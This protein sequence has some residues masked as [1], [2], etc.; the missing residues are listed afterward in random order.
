[1]FKC[2]RHT[3]AVICYAIVATGF[4]L[5]GL[6]YFLSEHLMTYHVEIL[7]DDWDT[8]STNSRYLVLSFQKGGGIG[9][10]STGILMFIIALIPFRKKEPWAKWTLACVGVVGITPLYLLAKSLNEFSGVNTPYPI[11]LAGLFI[12]VIGF[13]LSL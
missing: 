8:L 4:I 1:M 9:A 5:Q 11:V 2:T 10:F 13:F 6:V 7:D 12:I 3:I